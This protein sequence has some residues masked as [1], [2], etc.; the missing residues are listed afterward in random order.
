MTTNVLITGAT[1]LVGRNFARRAVDA[2]FKTLVM[3]RP[4]S[5]RSALD[6]LPVQFVEAD[7]EIPDTLP[8]ALSEADVVVNAAAHVGDWGPAKKYR[9]INVLGLAEMLK[10]ANR[11][12]RL[13]RLIQISSLGVYLYGHHYGTD[14]TI[15]PE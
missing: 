3:V 1:G 8:R 2:G 14:E 13:R 12:G 6:G 15:S 10:V 11:I 9:A 4:D 7:L 5:D